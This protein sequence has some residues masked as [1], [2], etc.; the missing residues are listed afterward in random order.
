MNPNEP[1]SLFSAEE[2]PSSLL[3]KAHGSKTPLRTSS[4]NCWASCAASATSTASTT[5]VSRLH[6]WTLRR[7]ERE[8]RLR[9][10]ERAVKQRFSKTH[11]PVLPG[12][13]ASRLD[14]RPTNSSGYR[15]HAMPRKSFKRGR[16][17]ASEERFQE[18]NLGQALDS[19]IL[20][21]AGWVRHGLSY[22]YPTGVDGDR[23]EL[24]VLGFRP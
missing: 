16:T 18:A 23:R 15:P 12:P 24:A 14:S 21:G 19:P 3:P 9:S 20:G 7:H 1:Y 13:L 2:R 5:A 6:W 10:S 8:P 17:L 4:T 22:C 11:L